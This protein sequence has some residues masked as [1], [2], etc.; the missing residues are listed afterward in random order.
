MRSSG[1]ESRI[2]ASIEAFVR[3]RTPRAEQLREAA[4]ALEVLPVTDDWDRDYGVRPDGDVIS[5]NRVAPYDP[6]AELDP[7]GRATVLGYAVWK[8]PELA[9]LRPDRPDDAVTCSLCQGTGQSSS[10]SSGACLCG[11]LGWRLAGLASSRGDSG[12]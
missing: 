10:S 3:S 5:F 2:R 8:F 6:R 4:L 1:V 7:R 12:A 11:G 9:D